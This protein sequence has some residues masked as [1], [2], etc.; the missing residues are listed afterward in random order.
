MPNRD[1]VAGFRP[2]ALS[3]A[4]IVVR[5]FPVDSANATAIFL[6]DLIKA[7]SD[8][9]V[10]PAAAG[11]ATVVLGACVGIYD[12]NGVAAGSERSS[13]SQNY[14]PASTAGYVDVALALSGQWFVVQASTGTAVN[15]TDRFATADHIAG[16]GDTTL[17]KSGH[18]LNS[19]GLGTATAQC[20]II[21]KLE[22]PDN[23]WGEHVD[24]IVQIIENFFSGTVAGV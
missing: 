3:P 16:A 10:A 12:S 17:G 9:N 14:L 13:V 1:N 8:G 22:D 6:G 24:L 11:D 2:Y 15:E 23:A 20:K 4:K 18:E 21:D 7:E 5:R 19:G